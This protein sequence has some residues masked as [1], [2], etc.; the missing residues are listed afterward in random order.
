SLGGFPLP[1][2]LNWHRVTFALKAFNL[3]RSYYDTLLSK[4]NGFVFDGIPTPIRE[5][6]SLPSPI[7]TA[8]SR[9][10]AALRCSETLVC[11]ELDDQCSHLSWP[12]K[13]MPLILSPDLDG[14][15]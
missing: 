12:K 9:I 3:N 10:G 7:F 5:A 6:V 11:I 15:K 2:Y 4:E 8:L 14:K 1:G 13:F